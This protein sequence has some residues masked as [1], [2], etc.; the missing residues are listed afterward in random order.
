MA[1]KSI[2][3]ANVQDASIPWYQV[4]QVRTQ[5]TRSALGDVMPVGEFGDSHFLPIPIM[6]TM[7]LEKIV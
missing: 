4:R 3:A 1:D 7:K 6:L 2:T 5:H